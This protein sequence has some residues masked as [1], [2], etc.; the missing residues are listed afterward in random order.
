MRKFLFGATFVVAAALIAQS[1][2]AGPSCCKKKANAETVAAKSSCSKAKTSCNS[3][4][5]VAA[6][7]SCQKSCDGFPQIR[8]MVAGEAYD[9]QPE[10]WAALADASEKYIERYTSIACVVDGKVKY[11]G[12]GSCASKGAKTAKASCSSAAEVKLAKAD[13]PCSSTK[14]RARKV[15]RTTVKRACCGSKPA[16]LAKAETKSCG[17]SKN[18]EVKLASAKDER[19]CPL[20]G[21]VVT[22]DAKGNSSCCK[23]PCGDEAKI[24]TVAAESKSGCCKSKMAKLA[25][26]EGKSCSEKAA[27]VKAEGKTCDKSAKL[28]KAE[29]CSKGTE[30]KLASAKSGC[31]KSKMAKLAKAEGKSCSEKAALVKAEGKTCDKSAKLA[32]AEGCSKG[33]EAKLASA[34]SGCCKSKMAKLAKAE[35]KSCSEKAALV[36]AESKTCDKSAKLAKAEGC[37]KGAE[38]KLASAKSGCCKSKEVKLASTKEGCCKSKAVKLASA[39]D[40]CCKDAKNVMYRVAGRNF[41]TYEEAA[42]A[43]E[44]A[45]EAMKGVR[46]AYVVDGKQVDCSS[47]VCPTMKKAGK[48][49]FV[50]NKM[51]TKCEMEARVAMAKAQMEAV[52]LAVN[53]MVAAAN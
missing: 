24:K 1:S 40:G 31:C 52:Q 32:K 43:R 25:K 41:K 48:V 36:K 28:A 50:V 13:A 26:A 23:K 37:S 42:E 6:K 45:M 35:G 11:C 49:K 12:E 15:Q 34:K 9:T 38:A 16:K 53:D 2:F 3:A 44:K 27:L 29:G 4:T 47:K 22:V 17:E 20:T 33:T 10:A 5:T 19:T 39:N 30:A 46:M 8:F 14:K 7:S 18:A 51:E 21:K